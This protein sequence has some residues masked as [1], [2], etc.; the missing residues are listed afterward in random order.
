MRRL[1]QVCRVLLQSYHQTKYLHR[2]AGSLKNEENFRNQGPVFEKSYEV[3]M[4]LFPQERIRNFGII[5]HIDHGKSTLSDRFLEFTG[6]I[7]KSAQNK[8]VLD[9][10]Q[11]ERERGI[12]V[13]AQSASMIYQRKGQAFLLNL[14]DT[15]GHVDF[16]YEVQRSLSACQGVLLLVDANQGVQAQTV[17]NFNLAFCAEL[18]IIPVLNK[19]DLPKANVNGVTEQIHNL[20]GYDKEEILKVSAKTG[21]GVEDLLNALIDR[22]PPPKGNP[23]A[24]FRALLVDSWYDKYRGVV[25][26][27]MV[28][29]GTLKVGDQFRCHHTDQVYIVRDVGIMH[30][31]E[32]PTKELRAGQ[33]GY[34]VANMRVSTEANIGDTLHSTTVKPEDVVTLRSADRSRPMVFAGI[35]PE[36]Q[37]KNVELRN[38]IERL[39]LNDNSVTVN[40]ESSPALGQGWRL[41]F[42][43]LLHMDV[44]CQRLDQEFDAQV[45]V[46]SPSVSYK[47]KIKGAK[48][49]KAYGGE[50][51]VVNNP[52]LMPDPLIIEEYYEPMT[53]ATIITPDIYLSDVVSLCM[54][55]RGLEKSSQ[56]IDQNTIMLQVMFPLNEIIV[57]FFDELKSITSGYASFDYEETGYLPSNL[58]KLQILINGKPCDEFTQI[59]H[60]SRAEKVG[61]SMVTHLKNNIPQ[62]IYAVA[63]Q[64]RAEGK[65]L[66]RDDVKALHKNVTQ[67]IKSGSDRTRKM[68]LISAYREK[69]KNLRMIGNIQVP[70]EAFIEVLKQRK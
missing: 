6:T 45:V 59:V 27:I 49:I 47:V 18:E 32:T 65:I 8:Q 51:V 64:A 10:L 46:T 29:D 36:D 17:A 30:P 53:L 63:L 41:G 23:S 15:P 54:S 25:I 22:I 66:A 69:Q 68:K 24:P 19:I 12:T 35:Y 60:S 57:N 21:Q 52:L 42:L 20:F 11:V 1:L 31:D 2:T 5:A 55:R 28:H 33:S 43:G 16:T 50:M 62:Q 70:R 67:K 3:D 38:A 26:L 48:N 44:F 37:S 58:S 34:V 61:R 56:N 40:V 13:K 7:G 39:V 14:I 9:K 4:S